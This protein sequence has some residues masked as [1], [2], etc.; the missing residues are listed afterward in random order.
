MMFKIYFVLA[1]CLIFTAI[2]SGDR[3]KSMHPLAMALFGISG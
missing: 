3:M 1:I 2:S